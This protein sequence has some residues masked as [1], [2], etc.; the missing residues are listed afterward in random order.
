M[1]P[2]RAETNAVCIL[3]VCTGNVFRSA[4]AEHYFRL[5]TPF[6]AAKV[7]SRGTCLYYSHPATEVV[8]AA[9][10]FAVD[11]HSHGPRLLQQKDLDWA[12]DV[13]V[14]D[15]SHFSFI[16]K[17]YYQYLYKVSYL[18]YKAGTGPIMI[19]DIKLEELAQKEEELQE[20]LIS[21]KRAID[22]LQKRIF[23]AMQ[24]NDRYSGI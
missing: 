8:R 12:T 23:Y 7:R 20:A 18:G 22:F 3:F 24:N 10:R 4:F 14:M 2:K 1:D 9:A 21:I 16:S 11:L 17:F 13:L 19:G 5:S 6:P 15:E